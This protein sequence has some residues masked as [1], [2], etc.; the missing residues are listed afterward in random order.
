ME[1]PLLSKKR[2]TGTS[3]FKVRRIRVVGARKTII[4]LMKLLQTKIVHL[5]SKSKLGTRARF[6]KLVMILSSIR[7]G[8]NQ[9]AWWRLSRR[10]TTWRNLIGCLRM[11]WASRRIPILKTT[12]LKRNCGLLRTRPLLHSRSFQ[13]MSKTWKDKKIW[14]WLKTFLR[15]RFWNRTNLLLDL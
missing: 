2:R 14:K 5:D 4:L 6:L 3:T 15:S 13:W 8:E 7:V 1:Q 12:R 10:K 9:K 11:G